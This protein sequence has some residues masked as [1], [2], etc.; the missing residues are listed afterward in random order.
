MQANDKNRTVALAA[1]FQ[2]V[3]GVMQIATQG[4]VDHDLFET[5]INSIITEKTESID[6]IY[7]DLGNLRKGLKILMHQLGAGTQAPNGKSKDLE[8]TRYS[9]NL[10][11]LEKKLATQGEIFQQ[12]LDGIASVQKQRDFFDSST[13]E[14]IIAKL[15]EIYTETISQ[16][17]PKIMVKGDQD[18]LSIPE[19]AAKI[20][21][22]LL[23]GIRAA[24]LWRQAGG[25]RWKLLFSRRKMQNEAEAILRDH[26]KPYVS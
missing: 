3:E 4:R 5:C 26:A 18:Q 24:L 13:H 17:G 15:A 16:V 23:A 10:L 11:Y 20:R 8:A 6:D 9:I 7:G 12:L 21:A 25:S 19:N 2:S 14:S 22:L 1:L